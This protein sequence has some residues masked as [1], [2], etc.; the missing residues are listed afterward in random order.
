MAAPSSCR[1]GQSLTQNPASPPMSLPRKTSLSV[2]LPKRAASCVSLP[3]LP[4]LKNLPLSP[5][6]LDLQGV[7]VE[8]VC[9]SKVSEA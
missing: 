8:P 4:P 9:R 3:A 2:D 6:H 5:L 7:S 1:P